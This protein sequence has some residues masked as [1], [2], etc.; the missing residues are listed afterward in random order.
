[1]STAIRKKSHRLISALDL[2]LKLTTG[3]RLICKLARPVLHLGSTA[4]T[5]AR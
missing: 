5:N 1:M 2:A 4:C 3:R